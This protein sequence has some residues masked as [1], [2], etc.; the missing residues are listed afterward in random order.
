MDGRESSRKTI[1]AG[2]S[3]T[4]ESLSITLDTDKGMIYW[5]DRILRR[6]QRCTYDGSD[7]YTVKQFTPDVLPT[8]IDIYGDT[9]Y[10][11]HYT[12][13]TVN[14]MA[15][16]SMESEVLAVLPETILSVKMVIFSGQQ[17]YDVNY[18]THN[19][20]MKIFQPTG[21]YTGMYFNCYMG[22][23]VSFCSQTVHNPRNPVSFLSA[24][25]ICYI[26]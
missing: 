8:T 13:L 5:S 22:P 25:A 20:P 19:V 9:L 4:V 7:I 11:I 16:S 10:W 24:F 1:V 12:S 15:L 17:S 21:I 26:F 6:I 23:L 14:A 18:T 3:L 2:K